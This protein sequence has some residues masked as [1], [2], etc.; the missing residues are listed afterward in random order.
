MQHRRMRGK[1]LGGAA[2]GPSALGR[3]QSENAN[4]VDFVMRNTPNRGFRTHKATQEKA[5]SGETPVNSGAA[6]RRAVRKRE[7]H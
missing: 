2:I 5:P 4:L 3:K 1:S 6:V 7:S